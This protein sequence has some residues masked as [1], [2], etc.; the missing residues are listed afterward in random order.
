[1]FHL[2]LDIDSFEIVEKS[3][4]II[5]DCIFEI[6]I[7]FIV[8]P[9]YFIW[10]KGFKEMFDVI[11]MSSNFFLSAGDSSIHKYSGT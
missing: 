7:I 6:G 3:C 8:G 4:S 11:I 10:M 1:M 5:I 9:G 2:V